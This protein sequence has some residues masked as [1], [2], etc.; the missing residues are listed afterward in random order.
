MKVILVLLCLL[1][2]LPSLAF[3]GE[4]SPIT[5]ET[6][7]FGDEHTQASSDAA[8]VRIQEMDWLLASDF[9]DSPKKKKA[10]PAMLRPLNGTLTSHF[11]PRWGR[12]HQGIDL[13]AP[14]GTMIQASQSGTVTFSGKLPGYGNIVEITHSEGLVTRYAHNE[15]NFVGLGESVE[16]GQ[17]IGI[18]GC[19]GRSTG[20]HLHFEVRKNGRAVNPVYF[21]QIHIKK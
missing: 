21:I 3:A 17:I 14:T 8:P 15:E 4:P 7:T 5:Y 12:M 13:A 2:V 18:V 20:P 6:Q 16:K 11:G 19:T 9:P 10:K 1:A